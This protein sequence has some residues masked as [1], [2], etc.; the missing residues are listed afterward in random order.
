MMLMATMMATFVAKNSN[1]L[2]MMKF[3]CCEVME[4]SW[5]LND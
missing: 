5:V 3:L 2:I 4:T 1:I